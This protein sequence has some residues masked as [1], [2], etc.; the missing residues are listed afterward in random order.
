LKHVF[1]LRA[2]FLLYP[3]AAISSLSL[4]PTYITRLFIDKAHLI[5]IAVQ[6]L[7]LRIQI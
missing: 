6:K 1:G 7:A 4:K 5:S 3:C 2:Q